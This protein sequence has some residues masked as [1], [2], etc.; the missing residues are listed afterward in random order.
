[1]EA[2]AC[3]PGPD[4]RFTLQTL[5]RDRQGLLRRGVASQDS[6]IQPCARAMAL[7]AAA[8]MMRV[9]GANLAQVYAALRLSGNS[10]EFMQSSRRVAH[11]DTF[12]GN[13]RCWGQHR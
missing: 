12:L 8:D 10:C 13:H 3:L 7:W 2:I 4:D 11:V 5:A 9:T 6:S 1:M